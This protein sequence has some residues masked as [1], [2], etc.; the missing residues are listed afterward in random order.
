[1]PNVNN[2]AVAL[3]YSFL[4]LYIFVCLF[5]SKSPKKSMEMA[6]KSVFLGHALEKRVVK[7]ILC[8]PL[9]LD[10]NNFEIIFF[11]L[12]RNVLKTNA[13]LLLLLMVCHK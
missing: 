13:L 6:C 10:E 7:E 2:I 9:L 5:E 4:T 12:I 11:A 3:I 1:M 8:K